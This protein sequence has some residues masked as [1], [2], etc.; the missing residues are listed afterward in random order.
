M[1]Q[2]A[3]GQQISQPVAQIV[4]GFSKVFVG[5]IVERGT[6]S[7]P[8]IFLGPKASNVNESSTRSPSAE[9]RHGAVVARSPARSVQ[10]VSGGDGQSG[11]GSA[12]AFEE[13]LHAVG[14]HRLLAKAAQLAVMDRFFEDKCTSAIFSYSCHAMH[15]HCSFFFLSFFF[16]L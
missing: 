14:L 15:L 4:A 1:V 8:F 9:R 12:F 13:A 16:L 11:R 7:P 3:L 5:E 10:D 6:I 2:Q